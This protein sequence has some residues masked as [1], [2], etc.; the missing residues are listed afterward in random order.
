VFRPIVDLP[1]CLLRSREDGC[2]GDLLW[3]SSLANA[4]ERLDGLNDAKRDDTRPNLETY[5]GYC[6]LVAVICQFRRA[7]CDVVK[8]HEYMIRVRS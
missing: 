1:P 2:Q 4:E 6:G 8:D 3:D 7:T 5:Y